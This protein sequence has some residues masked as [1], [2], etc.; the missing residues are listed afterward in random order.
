VSAAGEILDRFAEEHG[1]AAHGAV[2]DVLRA[3]LDDYAQSVEMHVA[4]GTG[5]VDALH[6]AATVALWRVARLI[7]DD[8]ECRSTVAVALGALDQA[9][10]KAQR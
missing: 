8:F 10:D 1:A 7:G 3:V 4:A 2:A 6:T 5:A 9:M